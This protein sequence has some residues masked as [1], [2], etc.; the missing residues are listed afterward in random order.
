MPLTLLGESS[1]PS[2]VWIPID[3]WVEGDQKSMHG[4]L[5]GVKLGTGVV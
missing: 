2:A 3:G 1:L 5:M 4:G